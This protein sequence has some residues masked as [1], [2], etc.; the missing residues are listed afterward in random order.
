MPDGE[1]ARIAID[2]VVQSATDGVLRALEAR[3][4]AA[5]DFTR[6]NGFLG[7]VLSVSWHACP[8][9]TNDWPVSNSR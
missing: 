7:N 1:L 8:R 4:I 6:D 5:T 9:T 2:D 3:K